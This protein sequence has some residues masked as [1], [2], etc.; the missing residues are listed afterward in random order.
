[1]NRTEPLAVID[2]ALTAIARYERPDLDARLRHARSRLHDDRVRVLVVGEFKQGKSMLVNGLV[3]APVC[4]TFDDIATAV[5][6]HVRHAEKVTITLVRDLDPDGPDPDQRRTERIEVPADEL[7][8]AR[9]RAGQPGQPGGL[10][11]RRGRGARGRCWP[12]GW[13]W[14][15]P[16]VSAGCSRCTARP[17]WPRCPAPTRCCWS[18]TPPRSTRPRSWSSWR[19]PHR[20]A[21]TWPAWSPRPTCTRRGGASSS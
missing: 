13:S 9:L 2:R 10:E 12:A 7:A 1:M 15:T 6:T 19:T 21:R 8:D 16:P 17:P 4:P 3:G 11:P 14:W 18:P 5:P 20:S